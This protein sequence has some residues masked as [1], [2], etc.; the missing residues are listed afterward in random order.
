[1]MFSKYNPQELRIYLK[2]I[3]DAVKADTG[4][5]WMFLWGELQKFDRHLE[6]REREEQR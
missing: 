2:P 5:D 3:L 4:D 1:M 6:I